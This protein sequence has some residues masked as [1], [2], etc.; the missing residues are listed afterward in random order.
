[1]R[2]FV[3]VPG[4]FS[5]PSF[6]ALGMGRT[7]LEKTGIYGFLEVV[8]ILTAPSGSKSARLIVMSPRNQ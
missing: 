8:W 2:P 4:D 3:T 5:S 6:L 7:L 1:M